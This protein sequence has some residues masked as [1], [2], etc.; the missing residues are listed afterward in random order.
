MSSAHLRTLRMKLISCVVCLATDFF[1]SGSVDNP[2]PRAGL[3]RARR[4][5]AAR[6]RRGRAFPGSGRDE[7][8]GLGEG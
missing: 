3:G 2:A 7:L 5:R 6:R 4:A 1:H 8:G